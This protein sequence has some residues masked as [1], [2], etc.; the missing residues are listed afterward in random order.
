MTQTPV[1]VSVSEA[2][3]LF[4][5]SEKTIRQALR[6]EEIQYIIVRGR[7]KIAF[8]SL[9]AWSKKTPRRKTSFQKKGIGQYL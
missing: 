2:A 8:S 4:G 5:L 6:Q 9:L 7:Y 3:R 1:R